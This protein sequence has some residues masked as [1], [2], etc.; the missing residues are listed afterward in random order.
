M[1]LLPFSANYIGFVGDAMNMSARL[2]NEAESG[3]IIV[4]NS[5]YQH[6]SYQ[7]KKRFEGLPSV[8]AKNLGR[9]RCWKYR[10]DG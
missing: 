4:S 5:F 2:M 7:G 6:L 3:G 9:I 8:E 1:P 10:P